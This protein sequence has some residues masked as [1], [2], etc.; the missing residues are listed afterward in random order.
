[1]PVLRTL[2][3]EQLKSNVLLK[4][5]E[6]GLRNF[7]EF[8]DRTLTTAIR[9]FKAG[10]SE[11]IKIFGRPAAAGLKALVTFVTG[12]MN[13]FMGDFGDMAGLTLTGGIV[14]RFFNTLTNFF[15]GW[16]PLGLV[17]EIDDTL[18]SLLNTIGKVVIDL[19]KFFLG[20][21]SLIAKFLKAAGFDQNTGGLIKFVL[22]EFFRVFL[23]EFLAALANVL[24]PIGE[25][26]LFKNNKIPF[27]DIFKNFPIP[28]GVFEFFRPDFLP[29][30]GPKDSAS[31]QI[32]QDITITSENPAG[33]INR[34]LTADLNRYG[35]TGRVV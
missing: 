29:K 33:V 1:M 20:K 8:T 27:M 28:G 19:G 18:S 12:R 17:R 5:I 10:F 15:R 3:E 9:Q 25:I 21:E 13:A 32:I 4:T 2:S 22:R 35:N 23:T 16:L 6:K 7:G 11:W 26:K 24:L 30:P 14:Q 31:I 34:M